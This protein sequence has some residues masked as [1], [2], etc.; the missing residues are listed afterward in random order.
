M[1]NISPVR[2]D[3]RRPVRSNVRGTPE[4]T[5]WETPMTKYWDTD[6]SDVWDTPYSY[7]RDYINTLG[8]AFY[9]NGGGAATDLVNCGSDAVIDNIWDGGGS[10]SLCFRADSDG[11][12]S[13]GRLLD[14]TANYLYMYQDDG[15]NVKIRF[16][17]NFSSTIGVWRTTD[18]VFRLGKYYQ[19]I[20]IYNADSVS[21]NPLLYYRCLT[22]NEEAFTLLTVGSGLTEDSTPIGI[23]SSDSASNLV[24]GNYISGSRT[25]D[26]LIYD[27]RLFDSILSSED[28]TNVSNFRETTV[29]PVA[30]YDGQDTVFDEPSVITGADSDMSGPNTWSNNLLTTLDIDT[31]VPDKMYTKGSGTPTEGPV[32]PGYTASGSYYTEMTAKLYDSYSSQITV[33]NTDGASSQL[34][35]TLVPTK[36]ELRYYGIQQIMYPLL[37]MASLGG[38]PNIELVWDNVTSR[39]LKATDNS[40]NGNDGDITA[41]SLAFFSTQNFYVNKVRL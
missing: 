16:R 34:D 12:I 26:G 10:V 11:E 40:G 32:W 14:K 27:V 31:T 18:N 37:I 36:E 13:Q 6:L 4:Q 21:N 23:R 25:H 30:V 38:M 28:I 7:E 8:K 41:E 35:F 15:T 29:D 5:W 39:P 2:T 33:A 24:I 9:F 20:L 1:S 22:D 3:V 17:C 19:I